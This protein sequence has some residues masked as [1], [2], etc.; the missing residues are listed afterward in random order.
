VLYSVLKSSAAFSF[1]KCL[2]FEKNDYATID[3]AADFRLNEGSGGKEMSWSAWLYPTALGTTARGLFHKGAISGT[4]RKY[5]LNWVS[6]SG[7]YYLYFTI[8][9]N[10]AGTISIGRRCAAGDFVVNTKQHVVVTYDG[11]STIKIYINKVQKDAASVN[12]GV[13]VAPY[14][15]NNQLS[16]GRGYFSS[17][18]RYYDGYKT[19]LAI[20]SKTLS[21]TDIDSLYNNG[22]GKL[23]FA[24]QSSYLKGYWRTKAIVETNKIADET[25][26]N[27]KITLAAAPGTPQLINWP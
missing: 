26:N 9:G 15:T 4:D 1:S 24:V 5:S 10:S 23:A 25:T 21:Q 19:E 3:D 18:I 22:N 12:A 27:R 20:W 11:V 6:I 16:L 17:A 14:S 8:F 7:T 13:W 2:S